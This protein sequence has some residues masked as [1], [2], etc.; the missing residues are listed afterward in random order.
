MNNSHEKEIAR[1]KERIEELEEELEQRRPI[2]PEQLLD[3]WRF[4]EVA[5]TVTGLC[6]A[7]GMSYWL[8]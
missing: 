1:L 3:A 6:L 5:M 7:V 2:H 8:S 4:A